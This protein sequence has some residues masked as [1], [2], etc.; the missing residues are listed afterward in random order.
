M[1]PWHKLIP[2]RAQEAPED[3]SVPAPWPRPR[4]AREENHSAGCVLCVWSSGQSTRSTTELHSI[5]PFVA[6]EG[7]GQN[8]PKAKRPHG[9]S[10]TPPSRVAIHKQDD[11]P[12]SWKR[13]QPLCSPL[14]QEAPSSATKQRQV[15]KLSGTKWRCWKGESAK[16]Q[17][18]KEGWETAPFHQERA[19]TWF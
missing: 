3:S 4:G 16:G 17:V 12:S 9:G 7:A 5:I 14:K 1:Q 13:T 2:S 10:K 6:L 19:K 18:P 11:V 8:Q 15:G